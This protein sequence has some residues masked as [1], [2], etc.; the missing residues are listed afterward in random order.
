[1]YH[2]V[3][4]PVGD[5]WGLCVRPEVFAAQMEVL[6]QLGV[7]RP[8]AEVERTG[9]GVAVTFDD[10]Y[11]D[12]LHA[13]VPVLERLE[14]PATV[15]VVSGA[16][17]GR[18]F[19]WDG[20]ERVLLR[21]GRL[22]RVV[23]LT[24]AGVEHRWVVGADDLEWDGGRAGSFG[25]WIAWRDEP[26]TSR[27]SIFQG[28]WEV[29]R[30]LVP[31][32]REEQMT[33]VRGWSGDL[34]GE[35]VARSLSGDELAAL[36]RHAL[37]EIGGHTV[38]HS[39]L[40]ALRVEEQRREIVGCR[41]ELGEV[42]GRPVESFSFP[43]GGSGDYSAATCQMVREAGYL[44]ACTTAGRRMGRGSDPYQ[45]PRVHVTNIGAEPFAEAIKFGWLEP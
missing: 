45:L 33:V 17:G 21:S 23:S 27:H 22:P 25:N 29:L 35:A 14:I 28:A 32:H 37:V 34:R 6:A 2:R 43:F 24:V 44:R 41:R 5:P 3:D 15:F 18:E 36:S 10:G 20:L 16:I 26:Q 8:L 12:N 4:A 7:A 11:A 38:T 42:T 19:W 30:G 39:R 1:M 31:E 9:R 40:S 13:A